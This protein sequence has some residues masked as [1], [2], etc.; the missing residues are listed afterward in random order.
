MSANIIPIL[1]SLQLNE[2][3]SYAERKVYEALRHQLPS[4]WMVIH[5]L[6]FIKTS[7]KSGRHSDREADFVIFAPEYGVLVVEVK[8][9]GIEFDKR[10]DQWFSTDRN[11]TKHSIKN[12]IRQAKDAKYEIRRHLERRLG[13][14]DILLAHAA[15][16][17]DINNAY[18]LSSPEMPT[19]IL[20]GND[21]VGELNQWIISVFKYWGGKNSGIEPLGTQGVKEAESLFGRHISVSASLKAAIEKETKQQLELTNQ[22]KSILRQLKRRKQAVIEGGAGT[23]KTVLA[24][25]HANDLSNLGFRTL[26]LCYNQNLGN[27]LKIRSEDQKKLHAMSFHEFCSW[28]I[29]QVKAKTR[30]DLIEESRLSYPNGGLFEVLMPDALINSYEIEPVKYDAIIIDEGQDLREEYWF[31]IEMLIDINP[32][33]NFYIFHDSNQA[34]YTKS[35]LPIDIEPLYLFDNCRNTQP[36]HEL[37]Y[38]RY[39]GIETTAS[40][41]QGEP[42]TFLTDSANLTDQTNQIDNLVFN[43]VGNE[44]ISKEDI[45]I[46]TIGNFKLAQ[47]YLEASRHANFWAFKAIS[48]AHHVLVET[49]K[50]FK[51]LESKLLIVWVLDERELNDALLYVALSRASLRLWIVGN[52]TLE[53]HIS[54]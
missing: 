8:G 41:I 1:D 16:F 32:N 50:R 28:R 54:A 35:K 36:I 9:G 11:G 22:Q 21:E 14:R 37:A 20:G 38:R 45:T 43:L 44:K 51:G 24:L 39:K 27:Q 53:E 18:Q 33:A 52:T 12:P 15:L 6:E 26:L 48:P 49:A 19:N 34:I 17:P 13:S 3:P 10:L 47:Q 2:I 23:G 31:A 46:L 42:V 30:R 5:S 25:D 4:S 29:R 40:S 7:Q